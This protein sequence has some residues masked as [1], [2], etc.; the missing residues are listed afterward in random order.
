VNK[1]PVFLPGSLL[2]L[3][4]LNACSTAPAARLQV[5]S[6]E[7]SQVLVRHAQQVNIKLDRWPAGSQLALLPGDPYIQQRVPAQGSQVI[8]QYG[9][10]WVNSGTQIN[11]YAEGAQGLE[12]ISE[13]HTE[14][15][16]LAISSQEQLIYLSDAHPAITVVDA[17]EPLDVRKLGELRLSAPVQTLAST[18]D[19]L[20]ALQGKTL[21]YIPL[22]NG[23]P[24]A[25]Q[26]Q[27]PL[28]RADVSLSAAP[29]GC[30]VLDPQQGL[31]DFQR[32][33]Q[34]L[35]LQGQYRSNAQSFQLSGQQW[36]IA[37]ADGRTGLTLLRRDNQ[38]KLQWA[39]SY[40]K[41]GS[42]SQ[43]SKLN[44]RVLV[45]DD[46][47]VLSLFDITRPE[48]PLLL[49]DFRLPAPPRSIALEQGLA[50]VLTD[51][52]LLIIDF[53]AESTPA[54]SNLGVNLGGSRRSFIQ[55]DLL[56]VADWFSGLHIYDIS[57]PHRLSLV[58]SFKT[59]GSPK[60]VLVR[61]GIAY[62]ADDD[63][64]MQFIDVS[65]PRHPKL[66]SHLPLDGLAYTM[67]LRG[68]LL[69]LAAHYGGFHILNVADIRHPKLVGTVNTPAKAW[70]VALKDNLA[71]VAD[72]NS[73]ILIFDV[74]DP[75][76]PGLKGV[77]DPK[78]FA[79][80]IVIRDN[81]AYVAFFDQGLH[82]LDL[83]NPSQ[84]RLI[85]KLATPGNARGIELVG[86]RLYLASWEAG[87]HI[88]DIKNPGRPS[89][90]SR[91]DTVGA[92]W[93]LS[94]KNDS[95][96]V[97]DW[98]GGV[99][100]IDI[101]DETAPIEVDQYQ[102]GGQI[103]ALALKDNFA[104]AA[105]G[106]RGLQVF[107]AT[108]VLNPVWATGVD[109]A[110]D[111]RDV[112]LQGETAFVAAGDGGL[113]S[114]DISNPFQS[115]WI[116]HLPLQGSADRIVLAGNTAFVAEQSGVLRIIDI[117]RRTQPRLLRSLNLQV[118]DLW[119]EQQHLFV[120]S[121]NDQVAIFDVKNLTNLTPNQIIRVN[122]PKIVRA[123]GKQLF[124]VSQKFGIQRFSR[125]DNQYVADGELRY[126]G[127]LQDLQLRDNVLY[128][129]I[130]DQGLL[131]LDATSLQLET[132]YPSTHDL[133]R[134]AL[135]KDAIFFAGEPIITS[136]QLL[137]NIQQQQHGTQITLSLPNDLP[138]GSYH[139]LLQQNNGEQ[140]WL[141]NAFKVSIPKAKKQKFTLDD[142][143]NVMKQQE[144][145]GQAPK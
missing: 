47:G 18:T 113:V 119:L 128:A 76:N 65:N 5:E 21:L 90:I 12:F 81:I 92:S 126:Q 62:V 49:S 22:E 123:W 136:A 69:Y 37:V 52:E 51:S 110:G 98:W 109:L 144:F 33:G 86:D 93:G 129:A 1:L 73:G 97:M 70:A 24:Q 87:V 63:K 101:S 30:L 35:K 68:D 44:N 25:I 78:G 3:G 54:I 135:T 75:A 106:S 139:L 48:T 20:C 91:Y 89:I 60:G 9:M 105:S 122:Q 132:L 4:L 80:D 71:Y 58:S 99:R 66:I 125:R 32:H 67:K 112:A 10:S 23:L 72:D 117:S 131:R 141:H 77:Y 38:Q 118:R 88:I 8:S 11:G 36:P 28:E 46:R 84:P 103:R 27:T 140:Q 100:S 53:S 15:P 61:D 16:I 50:H 111:A 102:A 108:N 14:Q 83:H 45:A 39:G 74:S 96:F 40:N 26:A 104:F 56:Y 94:V 31:L 145:S 138:L 42:I 85:S 6:V 55:D 127:N 133:S 82:I 17:S 19:H 41:L 57:V 107:D 137:S 142:L 121:D 124:V 29:E 34:Q 120:A 2:A 43:V 134:I 79:E 59:P 116:G 13:F 130:Q 95:I 115:H 143:K 7:P 114:I 64:G